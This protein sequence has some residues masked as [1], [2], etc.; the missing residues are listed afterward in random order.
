VF[1]LKPADVFYIDINFC[2]RVAA[3]F[4]VASFLQTKAHDVFIKN[5]MIEKR[6]RNTRDPDL[7]RKP[8]CKSKSDTV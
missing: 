6:E 7:S 4:K 1:G 8:L 5:V 2:K 3:S